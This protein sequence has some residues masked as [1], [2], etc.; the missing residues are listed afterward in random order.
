MES[1]LGYHSCSIETL[2][3]R[4]E[5]GAWT[6]SGGQFDWGGRLPK[7]NGGAQRRR[8]KVPSA[9][10]EIARK[11]VKALRELDSETYKSSWDESRA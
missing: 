1:M 9:R 6:M 10:L 4:R 7:G 2:T 3:Q 5:S 11:S 8:P